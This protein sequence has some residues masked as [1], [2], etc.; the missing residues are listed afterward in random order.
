MKKTLWNKFFI[1][2]VNGIAIILPAVVTV[3]LVHFF[4]I[5]VND[6]ILNPLLKLLAPF[7]EEHTYFAKALIFISVIFFIAL[8]GW[9]A[10]VIIINRVFGWGEDLLLRVPIMGRIYRAVKEISS[11][12][13]GQGRTIFKQVVLVEHPR[14]GLY[15]IGFTTGTTKGE[16]RTVIEENRINVFI[17]TTPNPTSGFF[18]MAL[19]EDIKF[20]KMSVENGMKLVI[21]GGSVTPQEL[22]EEKAEGLAE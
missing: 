4:V 10:R 21:S 20:L 3:W 13:L 8:I 19:K 9:G 5:K 6:A 14:K 7:G 11:A 16:I 15:S 18:I 12:L 2:F 1:G 17:P 22:A